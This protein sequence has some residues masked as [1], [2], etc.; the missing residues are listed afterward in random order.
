MQ[1]LLDPLSSRIRWSPTY[2]ASTAPPSTCTFLLLIN[3]NLAKIGII[4][5]CGRLCQSFQSQ[6]EHFKW[7]YLSLFLSGWKKPLKPP[8]DLIWT[9]MIHTETSERAKLAAVRETESFLTSLRSSVVR[10]L[11]LK[12]SVDERGTSVISAM[13]SLA[14]RDVIWSR[15]N[16]SARQTGNRVYLD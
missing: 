3:Q 8:S 11:G 4:I 9:R 16:T 14:I 5:E 1:F 6:H 2:W 10:L 7:L 13:T 15:W 12:H